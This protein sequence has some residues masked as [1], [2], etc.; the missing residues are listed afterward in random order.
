MAEDSAF[1][2]GA[3]NKARRESTTIITHKPP[4]P[5]HTHDMAHLTPSY[6]PHMLPITTNFPRL[7]A[8]LS[9]RSI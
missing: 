1:T 2:E 3:I 7:K 5:V 4:V 8:T 6:V 9:Q